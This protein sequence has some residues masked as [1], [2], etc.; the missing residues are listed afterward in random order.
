MERQ[1]SFNLMDKVYT[2]DDKNSCTNLTMGTCLFPNSTG[3]IIY[4][5]AKEIWSSNEK[6]TY[7][8]GY[9][10]PGWTL[11]DFGKF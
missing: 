1:W 11:M 9:R 6:M 2:T 3:P 5:T 4:A 7:Y 10:D 8:N